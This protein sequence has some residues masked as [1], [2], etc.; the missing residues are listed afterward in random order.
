M[1]EPRT[2]VDLVG[3]TYGRLTV[4]SRAA[5]NKHGHT[6]WNCL[7]L[8][9][10]MTVSP[11]QGLKSGGK[12]SCGCSRIKD[13]TGQRIGILTVV[14]VVASSNCAVWRCR[15]ECG[16]YRDVKSQYIQ[17]GSVYSCGCKT[18]DGKQK[19]GLTHH[20][21]YDTYVAMRHRCEIETNKAYP[22]YGG[23]GVHVCDRW[24]NGNGKMSGVECF[25]LDMGDRP[26]GMTLDRIDTNGG[27]S[28]ENC[29]WATTKSQS[30]NRRM[31]IKNRHV[32]TLIAAVDAYLCSQTAETLARLKS[33]RDLFADQALT[34]VPANDNPNSGITDQPAAA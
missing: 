30:R 27:Y 12:I 6:M 33:V 21:L 3:N 2:L 34:Y 4:V 13:R 26:E 5:N 24:K 22:D 14:E 16:N 11:G 18:R 17:S 8:C 23:R 1:A 32:E 7:C 28:P 9:G 15:C 19:H 20:Y 25:L 31:P 29:R 10:K